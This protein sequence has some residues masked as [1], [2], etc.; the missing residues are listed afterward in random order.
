MKTNANKDVSAL[1]A[2][3]EEAISAGTINDRATLR[4]KLG[5]P[6]IDERFIIDD[7]MP[8]NDVLALYIQHVVNSVEGNLSEAAR[9]L[10]V[11]RHTINAWLKKAR[12]LQGNAT[13]VELP[14]AETPAPPAA[15]KPTEADQKKYR[16][17]LKKEAAI[18]A[19][20]ALNEQS[21]Q[22]RRMS[23]NDG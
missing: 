10:N 12:A 1:L 21:R 6:P 13:T 22:R 17:L 20:F 15:P 16:K 2:D 4:N 9:L 18:L 14:I 5:L 8:L 11:H 23:N 3:L 19:A 7:I